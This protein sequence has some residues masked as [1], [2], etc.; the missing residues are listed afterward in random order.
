VNDDEG[1]GLV[2]GKLETVTNWR[3]RCRFGASFLV[4]P[5]FESSRASADEIF[6][7]S[8]TRVAARTFALVGVTRMRFDGADSFKQVSGQVSQN[9]EIV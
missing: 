8:V 2:G 1:L 3:C 7:N 5:Q 6:P 4:C 9:V